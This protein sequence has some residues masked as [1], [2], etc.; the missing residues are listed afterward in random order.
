MQEG[1]AWVDE[2]GPSG[3]QYWFPG[4]IDQQK[5]ETN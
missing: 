5:M 3:T 2:Q 1:F 4:L